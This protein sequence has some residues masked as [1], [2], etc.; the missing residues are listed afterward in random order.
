MQ[1]FTTSTA[2]WVQHQ[3]VSCDVW[4]CYKTHYFSHLMVNRNALSSLDSSTILTLPSWAVRS[5]VLYVIW[6]FPFSSISRL[7]GI[8]VSLSKRLQEYAGSRKL[9]MLL[10]KQKNYVFIIRINTASSLSIFIAKK[11]HS[12]IYT[13]DSQQPLCVQILIIDTFPLWITLLL[14][15][16]D[17]HGLA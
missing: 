15:I 11:C 7:T 14:F 5:R 16:A 4:F 6:D 1:E 9:M 8:F 17:H 10:A 13:S 3:A 12:N 2:S